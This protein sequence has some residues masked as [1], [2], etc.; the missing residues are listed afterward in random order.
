[1]TVQAQETCA[2]VTT[3]TS[4]S[5][6]AEPPS[7]RGSTAVAVSGWCDSG[8]SS[9]AWP[10]AGSHTFG[11]LILDD[12]IHAFDTWR[13][14][15]LAEH[16]VAL[17][18]RFQVVLFTHDDRLWRELRGL[19]AM[20]TPVRMDRHGDGRPQVRVTN[21]ASPGIQRLDEIQRVLAAE[22]DSPI[23]TP[24]A[25]TAMAS[26]MCRQAVDT[27]VVA[28]IEMLG[29]RVGLPEAKIVAEIRKAR[30]T[31]DQLTLL[32]DYARRAGWQPIDVNSF[33]PTVHALNGG[34]HGRAPGGE[35]QLWVRQTRKIINAVQK[36]RR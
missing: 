19:G 17:A 12:P 27:E 14:R 7:G 29:R 34:A 10:A 25:L 23:E 36:I 13:V 35:P 30:K 9:R 26:A 28:Q 11:F 24:S 15:Y 21:V 22:K 3:G 31:L 16:L 20:P 33:T 18:E 2:A 4:G 6:A 32:N 8:V 5:A 1:M